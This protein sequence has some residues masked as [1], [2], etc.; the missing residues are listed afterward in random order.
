METWTY[1]IDPQAPERSAAALSRAAEILKRGGLVVFPTETVYGLGG[2]ALNPSAASAI[3]LAKGRPS[4]NPLIVHIAHPDEA[5]AVVRTCPLYY[6]LSG[7]F[8]PGPLTMILPK[9]PAV[10]LNVT[11]GLDTV[12]IR[13]PSHPVARALI[14]AAGVPIAAPSANLSGS[15]SPTCFDHVYRD[16]NGRVDAILDG[17]PCEVGVESTIVKIEEDGS[18]TLL[19]PG[20]ITLEMLRTVTPCVKVADAVLHQLKENDVVLSPGMKYRHYAPAAPLTLLR[21]SI[22]QK[23]EYIFKQNK[24]CALICYREELD[25]AAKLLPGCA[26][27]DL[28]AQDDESEQ[29]KRLF[30]LLREVD[31]LGVDHIYAPL[32]STSGMGMAIYNRMIRAASHD[33]IDLGA[34]E[35][36]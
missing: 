14:R 26:L 6:A 35:E 28:G 36:Q 25:D 27:L 22:C 21:G 16:M 3:Y 32:P 7:T 20:A 23:A 11:A 30:A 29:A 34:A 33:V 31:L 13:C 2:N 15:P 8:W 17:G 4:D 9:L 12:A 24:K 10:P 1:K 18:L 5:S 19:R